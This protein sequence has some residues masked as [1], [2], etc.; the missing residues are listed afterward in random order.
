MARNL[1]V[2]VLQA[3]WRFSR[4]ATL[5]VRGVATDADGRV[6]LVKHTYVPGW[7]LPGGG[8]EKGETSPAALLREMRE[9]AGVE[10]LEEPRLISV[11]ANHKTFP[12]DHVLLFHVHAWR[13]VKPDSAGEIAALA[14]FD[15]ASLPP[16]IS[17]GTRRRLEEV[18]GGKPP[19]PD[20]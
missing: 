9:E 10:A 14:F 1:R 17:A 5:G 4:P 7:H 12:N 13:A 6:L 19:S 15:P 20:W 16:D 8:V 18:F 2:R 11:H 3:W